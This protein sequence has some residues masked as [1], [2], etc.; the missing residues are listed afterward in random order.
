[1]HPLNIIPFQKRPVYMPCLIA[2]DFLCF[3]IFP[4]VLLLLTLINPLY[5]FLNFKIKEFMLLDCID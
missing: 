4:I 5:C 3:Y 1:M 2:I